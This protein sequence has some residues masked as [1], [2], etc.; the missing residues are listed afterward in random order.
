MLN[1]AEYFSLLILMT[2]LQRRY[3]YPGSRSKHRESQIIHLDHSLVPRPVL[4][5]S[6][7][8]AM[9]PALLGTFLCSQ[10]SPSKACRLS[11]G[12]EAS[13]AAW[14]ARDSLPSPQ[15]ASRRCPAGL[16]AWAQTSRDPLRSTALFT[17]RLLSHKHGKSFHS[18]RSSL[19]SV[20]NVLS[21]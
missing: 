19:T 21:F 3:F 10:D 14:G 15:L 4:T 1:S 8:A 13:R 17:H 20:N 11:P 6:S 7:H 9:Q 2:I 16:R 12:N 5:A 18:L